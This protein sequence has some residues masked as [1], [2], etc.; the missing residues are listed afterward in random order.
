VKNYRKLLLFVFIALTAAALLSP[1]AAALWSSFFASHLKFSQIFGVLF[2]ATASVIVLSSPSLFR[3]QFLREA[4]LAP[5]RDRW[6]DLLRGFVIAAAS[7][8]VLGVLMSIAG[9]FT[10]GFFHTLP[11]VLQW[12]VKSLLT[13]LLVGFFEELF[14]RGMVFK[15]LLEDA[16]PATA[17]TAANLFYAAVH[18]FKPPEKFV[19]SGL[20]PL[21]GVRYVAECLQP[22]L[23]PAEIL[24]G[25]VGLFIIGL[26][27][28][29]AF[30]R[31]RALYLSI[32]LHAGWVFALK[33]MRVFGEFDRGDLGWA[34]GS[35]DPK[36][37][38]GVVTWI[39]VAVVGVI[40]HFIT[41]KRK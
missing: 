28:S 31:T 10:P 6:P 33:I 20:D 7:M 35:T 14:F 22:F 9:V 21:A 41:R 11:A 13:G 37:V 17:F 23:D 27:L 39:G 12:T 26:V 30:F 34:F 25:L 5:F 4:G 24:P 29:Y 16:R 19:V 15:G 2:I 40:V 18:F 8:A 3:L 38:S 32:G 36:I 1:W